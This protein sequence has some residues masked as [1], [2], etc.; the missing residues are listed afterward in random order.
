MFF[1][2]QFS[3]PYNHFLSPPE[4]LHLQPAIAHTMPMVESTH[5]RTLDSRRNYCLL[6]IRSLDNNF[7]R[8]PKR[9][10]HF[11]AFFYQ[12]IFFSP[13][14]YHRSLPEFLYLSTCHSFSE[15]ISIH[16]L[17]YTRI[18]MDELSLYLLND[19]VSSQ[20]VSTRW[21]HGRFK[22]VITSVV[23]FGL[24]W[25]FNLEMAELELKVQFFSVWSG[26]VPVFFQT[27]WL[28]F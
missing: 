14:S 23:W 7:K 25:F 3:H 11:V 26:Q 5:T 20:S 6:L 8:S 2:C 18:S 16:N 24:G 17:F 1:L 10:Y 27:G 9:S 13:N 22:P 12:L 15:S 19:A 4:F 28:D 21:I